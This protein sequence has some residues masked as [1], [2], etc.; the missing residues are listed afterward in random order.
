MSLLCPHSAPLLPERRIALMSF[1]SLRH[2]QT[3][4]ST[5]EALS[6]PLLFQEIA[7]S[8]FIW[9]I[10]KE[11][12][13]KHS[14]IQNFVKTPTAHSSSRP[15]NAQWIDQCWMSNHG[16]QRDR[17]WSRHYYLN[18]PLFWW[19][20]G[21]MHRSLD[22]AQL[23]VGRPGLPCILYVRPCSVPCSVTLNHSTGKAGCP[24]DMPV[25]PPHSGC[26]QRWLQSQGGLWCS[27]AVDT[28]VEALSLLGLSYSQMPPAICSCLF[29]QPSGF[30]FRSLSNA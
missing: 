21:G 3:L 26:V 6:V 8:L 27:A 30:Q 24:R 12:S 20:A 23:L 22:H 10:I 19:G 15:E 28:R 14:D 29:Q 2:L 9:W 17:S 25:L 16:T 1:S 4:G 7:L 13:R 5:L 18:H 11:S